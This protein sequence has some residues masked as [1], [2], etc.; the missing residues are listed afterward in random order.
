MPTIRKYETNA[1]KQAAYRKRMKQDRACQ[2]AARGLPPLP[3]IATMPGS[4]RWKGALEQ[5]AML[6][7]SVCQEMQS[8]Q[9]ERSQQWQESERGEEFQ[10]R[11]QTLSNLSEELQM[12]L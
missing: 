5:A 3:A 10:E 9:E 11:L 7:E 8:Y 4:A 6:L 1:E 2:L 12:L